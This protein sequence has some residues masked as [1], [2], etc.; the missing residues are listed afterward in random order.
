MPINVNILGITGDS[1]FDIYICQSGGTDCYYMLTTSNT[2]YNFDIPPPYDI[3]SS[4]MLKV[5][6][7]KGCV[8]TGVTQVI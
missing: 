2:T 1:P 5:I 4:Y 8:I 3:S 7:S 6:D